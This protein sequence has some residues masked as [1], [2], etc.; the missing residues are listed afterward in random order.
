MQTI[1]LN[2]ILSTILYIKLW[3]YPQYNTVF[4]KRYVQS[5]IFV[6]YWFWVQ[7]KLQHKY[8]IWLN[9]KHNYNLKFFFFFGTNFIWTLVWTLFSIKIKT[10]EY[11][12]S[13]HYIYPF[14]INI[15]CHMYLLSRAI[16]EAFH[17]SCWLHTVQEFCIIQLTSFIF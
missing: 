9:K 5:P 1:F 14:A 12:N 13:L 15:P 10:S 3:I 11:F 2:L 6:S 7:N 4:F 16:S 17:P 8:P